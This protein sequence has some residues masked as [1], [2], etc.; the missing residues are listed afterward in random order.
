MRWI[1]TNAGVPVGTVILPDNRLWAGGRLDPFEAYDGIGVVLRRAVEV[2]GRE[3]AIR[4]LDLGPGEVPD[5]SRLGQAAADAMVAAAALVF[6]LQDDYQR[7]AAADVVRVIDLADGSKPMV[8]A[9][10]RT[11][12][13]GTPAWLPD[14]DARSFDTNE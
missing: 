9:R 14:S 10:F 12:G 4:L 13:A 7:P 5:L 8:S 6:E 11:S 2:A 3:A 1:V